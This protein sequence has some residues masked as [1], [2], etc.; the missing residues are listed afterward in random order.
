MN[1]DGSNLTPLISLPGGDF[2]PGWSPDGTKIAFCSIRENIPHIYLYNLNDNSVTRLTS[3]SSNDRNPVWSPDGKWI[4]FDSNRLGSSQVWIMAPDGSSA[5]EFSELGKGTAYIP[6]WSPDGK[7]IIFGRGSSQPWLVAKQFTTQVVP[8]IDINDRIRSVYNPLFSPDGFWL[9]FEFDI[10]GSSNL[11]RMTINGSN[12]TQITHDS[13]NNFQP[14][15]R[16]IS[17]P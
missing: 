4:A 2:D 7:V 1:S 16:P 12:L 11:Y 17:P 8:E 15:L 3:P 14:A 6:A 13:G 5:H 9:I 10:N